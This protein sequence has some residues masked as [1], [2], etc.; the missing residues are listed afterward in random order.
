LANRAF[1]L[2]PI[3]F[4]LI[5]VIV[6]SNFQIVF[7]EVFFPATGFRAKGA[8]SYC[9]YTPSAENVSDKKTKWV[10][11]ARDAVLEWESK[12]KSAESTSK[13]NWDMNAKII[14]TGESAPSDCDIDIYFKDKLSV[15]EIIL[16]LFKWPPGEITIYYLKAKICNVIFICFDDNT[17]E[18]DDTIY[19]VTAHELGHSLGLDHYISDDDDVNKNWRTGNDPSPSV[20]IPA[21]HSNP[22]LQKI[23]NLD[24]QKVRAIY[25]TEGFNAFG[26]TVVPTPIPIPTPTPTPTPVPT[27]T[28]AP[29]IIPV[30]PFVSINVSPKIVE[31]DRHE[32]KMIQISGTISD[33][34]FLKGHPVLITI[35]RPDQSVQVLRIRTTD[36]GFFQVPMVFDNDSTRGLYRISVSYIEHVDKSMD[37]TFEVRSKGVITNPPV[38]SSKTETSDSAFQNPAKLAKSTFAQKISELKSKLNQAENTLSELVFENMFA[39][40]KIVY[41][42]EIRQNA[43]ANLQEAEKKWS[44]GV[45]ELEKQ[46]FQKAFEI[47]DR[48]DSNEKAIRDI[49]RD[50][51]NYINEASNLGTT[52]QVQKASRVPEWIKN[53]AKWWSEGQIGDSDFVSGIQH[54]MKEKIINIPDLPKQA[55]ETAQEQVPDWIRNNAGWWADGLITEDDFVTGIQYLVERGIIKV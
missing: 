25:G 7:A 16:G 29:P 41:A 45:Y 28:P 38:I 35:H 5:V 53:N 37:V 36:K 2:K 19:T 42:K 54:L 13:E 15:L 48:I 24:V 49:L 44:A 46:S 34:E 14:P 52:L 31:V 11:L 18:S 21:I 20:M 17:F 8:P 1:V 10:N 40:K 30:Q 3:V 50:I 23:T 39:Q 51:D 26:P 12:L 32:T 4:F 9:I 6:T 55:S 33:D 27:P 22:S 47:F 43:M